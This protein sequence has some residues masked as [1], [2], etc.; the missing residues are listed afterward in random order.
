M[1][2]RIA[3]VAS[4]PGIRCTLEANAL[5]WGSKDDV[6]RVQQ[7]CSRPNLIL[8][9]DLVYFRELFAPL[10]R[11]LI[12]LTDSPRSNATN[13]SATNSLPPTIV[14]AY[15]TR[16][17]EKEEDFFQAFCQSISIRIDPLGSSKSHL[18][19]LLVRLH[20]CAHA[21]GRKRLA[22]SPRSRNLHIYRKP[23]TKYIIS[24]RTRQRRRTFI[25]HWRHF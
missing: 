11:T 7:Q 14:M 22:A 25:A 17:L 16:A 12:W 13:G 21:D 10:L 19:S 4:E 1:N 2:G 20:T 23:Q 9:S 8:A 24:A 15:K 5:S 18:E 6:E 3:A